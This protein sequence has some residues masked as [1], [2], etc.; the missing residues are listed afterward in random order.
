M[1]TTITVS[2]QGELL[3]AL[4]NASGGDTILLESGNYGSIG[5]LNLNYS[6]YVT[7]KSA[8][9]DNQARF[10]GLLR[11]ENSSYVRLEDLF[12][13]R[14]S[15][16]NGSA[17]L[18]VKSSHH[19]QIY[20]NRIEG[21]NQG[22]EFF[23]VQ[24]LEVVGNRFDNHR[25][26]NMKFGGVTNFLIENNIGAPN[27]NPQA[28]D[29]V[30]FIQFQGGGSNGIIRG[31]V[32]LSNY[33]GP[34]VY[35]GI[36]LDDAAF[37]NILI[38]E[39]LIYN[40]ALNGIHVFNGSDITIRNNTV[41][42]MPNLGHS[43]SLIIND[44][45][46]G[47]VTIENNVTNGGGGITAQYTDPNAPNYYADI[48]A[49]AL[50][51]PGATIEDF[52]P[53]AG[54][55]GDFGSG[56]GAEERIAELLNGGSGTPGNTK[57]DAGDDNITTNE[58][59]S[60]TV[61]AEE[62]LS[63]DGDED[64]DALTIT[65]VSGGDNGTAVLNG[66]G[67]ITYTPDDDFN[68]TG[69][70]TYT[71]SDGNGG[72]DTAT[73]TV[74]VDAMP[75]APLA[76]DDS[77]FASPDSSTVINV[78]SNDADPDGDALQIM[79][80]TQGANGTVTINADGTLTY[81]PTGAAPSVNALASTSN[82]EAPTTDTFTYTVMDADGATDSATVT[83][84]V[85]EF[86][87]PTFDLSGVHSFNGGTADVINLPHESTFELSDATI[88]F[89][90]AAD[91]VNSRQG[92]V[93]KDASGDAGGGNHLAIY[94]DDGELIARF[95][96]GGSPGGTLTYDGLS[97]NQEYEVAA[98]FGVGGIEL[99]VDGELVASNPDFLMS[100]ETNQ[101]YLQIGGLGWGSQT[102][103]GDFTNPFA[104]EIEDVQIYGQV[105][106][107][108]QIAS[109]AS[110]AE[111]VN[112]APAAADDAVTVAED[113]SVTFQ[114]GENDADLDGDAV[115]ASSIASAPAHGSAVVNPDGTVTYTPDANFNGTD[116]FDVTVSDGN[117][118][119]DTSSV[120]VTVTSANDAPVAA[121]DAK[122]VSED[123]S[124]TFQPGGN[125]TDLDGDTVVASAIASAPAN[126][127][128]I[129][130]PDGTVTYTPDANFHGTDSFDVTVSD[131][132]GGFDTSSVDVTVTPVNDAPVA[133][134]DALTMA[135]DGSLTFEPS[136]NDT[137]LDGDT[138]VAT[139]IA[140]APSHGTAVVNP[141]G[142]VTYT[143]HA[144]FSGSDSFDV[145]VSD[146][147]G[148]FDTSTVDVTVAPAGDAPVAADDTVSVVEDGSLTFQPGA[149]DTDLDG[150]TVVASA[151]ASAPT[152][153]TAVVNP[154]GTVTYTPHAEFN[155]SDSFDVTVTDGNG[156]FDTS[157]V[158]VNVT[159]ANDAPL[160]ADDEITVVEDGVLT[161]QPG[162][163]DTD[164]DGDT[165]LASSI[166]A[167]PSNGTATV[168]PDGTVTYTPSADFNGADSFDVTVS[169]GNGGYD[170]STVNVTVTPAADAPD[171]VDDAASTQS[172]TSVVIDA[173]GNDTDADGDTL[174]VIDVG[175]AGNG[176][177]A[178]NEDGT[179][180]YIPDDGFEGT[181][182]FSYTVSDGNGG[183]GTATVTVDVTAS[184]SPTPV[185]DLAG[186]R[187]FSG[188]SADVINLSHDAVFETD[189]ATIAFSFTADSVSGKRGLISKDARDYSGDGNHLSIYID[190][191]V[192]KARFQDGQS[193]STLTFG[194]L[195]AGQE[196][197]VAATFGPDGIKLYVDG[198]LVGSNS[199]LIM[200]WTGNQEYLQV[201]GL[202]WASRTGDDAF[203][204]AF[205]GEMADVQIYD[206]VL[207]ASEIEVLAS[208]SR[209]VNTDPVAVDDEITVSEDD[210]L[211][212]QPAA[213]DTDLDGDT[214]IASSIA[215]TPTNGTAIVNPDG[216]VTYTP[217][218]DF[219]GTDTFD[220]TV[221]DG[222]GGYDIST[223][224]VTVT[225]TADAPV[226]A[227][228]SAETEPGTP[229]VI[230]ALGNDVDADGDALQIVNVGQASNGSV[231][232]NQDGTLTYTPNDGFEGTDNFS[233][234]VSD[235]N[236]RMD[237]ATVSVAVR[238]FPEAV[239]DLSGP[240][241]FSGSSADVI[242][243]PHDAAFETDAATIAFSFTADSVSGKR[244]LISKDARGY[245]GDGNHVSIYIDKGVLKAR[246]QDGQSS[247]TLKFGGLKTGQEY[248][249]AA[250]FGPDGTK[251]Y[252]NGELVGSNS[253]LIMSWTGNQ[254]YLQVGGLGWASQTGDDA[255][256][257]AFDGEMADVQ[258][259]DV[260]LGAS[261]INLLATQSLPVG[262]LKTVSVF[263]AAGD[264]AMLDTGTGIEQS[265]G[266]A[267][268]NA[269]SGTDGNDK[270]S[271]TSAADVIGGDDGADLLF[272]RGGDDVLNGGAGND[273]LDGGANDDVMSGGAGDD[274]YIGGTGQDT[275]VF[276]GE[277]SEF[278]FSVTQ[279]GSMIVDHVGGD[280]TE[281]RDTVRSDVETLKFNGVTL[282]LDDIFSAIGSD[283]TFS[284]EDMIV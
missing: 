98:T 183:T 150:D 78:L 266:G 117:G 103:Q 199:G 2:T 171:A 192:L 85:T 218:A 122:T 100:W 12:L 101:E 97:A 252:V 284:G 58:D 253:G 65:S 88:A 109:L 177:V 79:Q 271:G 153:G 278:A 30:D 77:V 208:G 124:L 209:P 105:L 154:D 194:G 195:K 193:S 86:P 63:N 206:Q 17:P 94:L 134:D 254:E 68:G 186:P 81:T 22:A 197:E 110:V 250:T 102:G 108:S 180:T 240:H 148:G 141:D 93:T 173:A 6:D 133:A 33:S 235:G 274:L 67:S 18:E 4:N 213:N 152:H 137:D 204:Y 211:T 43:K 121:D 27:I 44:T 61:A 234:I 184:S 282:D 210:V 215:A 277:V 83:V 72:F 262:T 96:N 95:Q 161:F 275:I 169:D 157:T 49:N 207:D 220:V 115:L 37:T 249:V 82:A 10:D 75:D 201:G 28:G 146:G 182:N 248:K 205:D 280:G 239:F 14:D 238:S 5:E 129:V 243:L 123:G 32:L 172:G 56:F 229:I 224:E 185:F 73:V 114:P 20:N 132:N 11:L 216:T 89:S 13:N 120:D 283:G 181:D 167:A 221:T 90:F 231:A 155:G 241:Q 3:S 23:G 217:N 126:G 8:D 273:T 55:P 151:I 263:P 251:L 39:N 260:E 40:N 156:G 279:D 46:I 244:G 255:F 107:A 34:K 15:T 178:I 51:G 261:E 104:G 226:A 174:Q 163:N 272:G 71:V 187:Q 144:Q 59:E 127:T 259:Y 160:A 38:E 188:S 131:G 91:T 256:R 66:D 64:G 84:T 212:F 281:G 265:D 136:A 19:I 276:N 267:P 31:N 135:E 175:Q 147:N 176:S 16:A 24:H 179:L 233:Y 92:L 222:K 70:F 228:D 111:P 112:N 198:E 74:N 138:I 149:N 99:Y 125:D 189:A 165:V 118:G 190:K 9:P 268:S 170:I 232:I 60:V 47:T 203:R 29:H 140:S 50:H 45:P 264:D 202:G 119:F 41:L 57:P 191:G 245:A 219:S 196:Y 159:S 158:E 270:L 80:V 7:I 143:P 106:D 130:N 139:A 236:G 258:I 53:V 62:L 237:T 113:G 116:S 166:A 162:A 54:G 52:R 214:V 145:T 200:S 227:D 76:E 69:S 247:S 230:D 42:T 269:V 168:N 36:F 26:D 128:A 164:L 225:P 25:S 35:Q 87:A 257:Y 246:F 21:G 142:T 48:Y 242:N 1:S 223:V